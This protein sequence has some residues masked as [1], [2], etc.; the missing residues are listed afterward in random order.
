[1]KSWTENCAAELLLLRTRWPRLKRIETADDPLLRLCER[2]RD[3]TSRFR[4]R[5]PRSRPRKKFK[6]AANATTTVPSGIRCDK[7]TRHRS[8]FVPS[9]SPRSPCSEDSRS[10]QRKE[11]IGGKKPVSHETE[12]ATSLFELEQGNVAR[13]GLPYFGQTVQP[14]SFMNITPD[15]SRARHRRFL[16][17]Q[18]FLSSTFE[19]TEK[20]CWDIIHASFDAHDR[21]NHILRRLSHY[22]SELN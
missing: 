12:P 4:S 9:S 16:I 3:A 10:A 18:M 14:V 11:G 20:K 6:H 19:S 21:I 2:R 13:V 5:R 17:S 22:I 1:M 7:K 8:Y 15:S